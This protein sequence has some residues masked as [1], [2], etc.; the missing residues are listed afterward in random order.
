MNKLLI[1]LSNF[2]I[3]FLNCFQSMKQNE[4]LALVLVTF[5]ASGQMWSAEACI[6]CGSLRGYFCGFHLRRVA[7]CAPNSLYYC[8]NNGFAIQYQNCASQGGQCVTELMS[9]G[10]RTIRNHR[11]TRQFG[12]GDEADYDYGGFSSLDYGRGS[13]QSRP[14]G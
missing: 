12:D 1:I 6:R 4:L 2:L 14:R 11:C 9:T 5:L 8:G 13:S 3:N 7:R 10:L